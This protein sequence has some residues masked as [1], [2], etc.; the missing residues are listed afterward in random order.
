MRRDSPAK[1]DLRP[2]SDG[3]EVCVFLFVAVDCRCANVVAEPVRD[4]LI[5]AKREPF[6][7]EK[8]RSTG[9]SPIVTQPPRKA[10][11]ANR[12]EPFSRHSFLL[13]L[14][15]SVVD[16]D[17]RRVAC[18][19]RAYRLLAPAIV[20]RNSRLGFEP[21]K[22]RRFVFSPLLLHVAM[23]TV[24]TWRLGAAV[25]IADRRVAE[26]RA[27]D[28]L[29]F[30]RRELQSLVATAVAMPVSV[31][32]VERL[33]PAS[34]PRFHAEVRRPCTLSA[35]TAAQRGGAECLFPSLFPLLCRD[36]AFVPV[37]GNPARPGTS[38]AAAQTSI[39][40]SWDTNCACRHPRLV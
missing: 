27:E 40:S 32:V 8:Q 23:R 16:L 10:D 34:N 2:A 28:R 12:I 26:K 25:R 3:D 14:D 21:M 19:L 35:T 20:F 30:T 18:R 38:P 15:N 17:E 9:S 5:L 4:D 36:V 1:F 13:S 31:L 22:E 7:V 29:P 24:K 37:A 33:T 11:V 39:S 6:R